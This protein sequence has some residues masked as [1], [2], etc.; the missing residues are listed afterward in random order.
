MRTLEVNLPKGSDLLKSL[1]E[2][3]SKENVTGY[4]LGI[5]GN[6]S[7]AVF[8]CPEQTVKTTTIGPLEI[9]NLN[10]RI[11]PQGVHLHL[12][13]S[14]KNCAVWGGHLEEGTIILKKAEILIGDLGSN[15]NEDRKEINKLNN[16]KQNENVEIAILPN[17][18]WSRR[19]VNMLRTLSIPIK[20]NI[21]ENEE[22][23]KE[24]KTRTGLSKFPQI[25]INGELIGGYDDLAKLHLS[26]ELEN[27]R[28]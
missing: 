23:F 19:A 10:G 3:S 27:L 14:D 22:S 11:S 25:F 21:I 18:P 6:L 13:I 26:G 24:M 28:P 20:L 16:T 4:I 8:Q 15:I 7:Q 2:Y 12:C 9:L 17:C 1:Q 5:V